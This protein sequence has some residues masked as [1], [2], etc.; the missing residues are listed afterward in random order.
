MFSGKSSARKRRRWAFIGLIAVSSAV[1][2]LLLG[3]LRFVQLVH[4]KASDF[5]FLVR[6]K[7]P[8]SNI[9]VIAVDST[10]MVDGIPSTGI[11]WFNYGGLTRDVS[12]IQVPTAFVDDYRPQTSVE[13]ALVKQIAD[14]QWKLRRLEKLGKAERDGKRAWV[15]VDVTKQDV[16]SA[17]AR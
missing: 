17:R 15:L 6:G 11:D 16:K 13:E 7:R 1:A 9:V 3:N 8:V 14:A 4:L 5:H 2:T 10:R 12:L